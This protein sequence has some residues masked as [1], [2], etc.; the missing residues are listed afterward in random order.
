MGCHCYSYDANGNRT[1]AYSTGACNG[2]I[3]D[4][5]YTYTYDDDGHMTQK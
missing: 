2:L 4:G 1:M 5:T 3:N